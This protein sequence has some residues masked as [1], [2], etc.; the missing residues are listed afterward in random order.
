M[1]IRHDDLRPNW[2]GAV[3][4]ER[5]G[6]W[7]RPWRVF[8]EDRPLLDRALLERASMPAGVRIAF[9]STTTTV[10]G[11]VEPEPES[12]PID[13]SVDGKVVASQPVAGKDS[14]RFDVPGDGEKLIELWLPQFGQ[15]RLKS[16]EIADD[17]TLEG[18]LDYRQR[19]ITY[20][21]SITQCRAAASPTQT[22]PAI[23]ARERDLNLTCLGYGGQCHLDPLIARAMRDMTADYFSICVGIN[24]YGA[25]SLNRRTFRPGICAFVRLIRDKHPDVPFAVISPIFSPPREDQEN[26]VGFTLRAM[27]K[28]VALAVEDLRAHGDRNVHYVNGLD[29]FG[30]GLADLLPDQLHPNAEGYKRLAQNFLRV[31]AEPLFR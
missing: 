25:G 11:Q 16:L 29:I 17:A 8:Q 14:F 23:V 5:T 27:R 12:A 18:R 22:W 19:W 10:T 24:I 2:P 4:V 9:S 6:E 1:Q 13:L 28:E 26:A 30:P 31:V 15:F 20:G 3:S 21:S 7:S